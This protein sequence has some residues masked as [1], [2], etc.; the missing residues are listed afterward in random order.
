MR[1]TVMV[2]GSSRSQ[3][4]GSQT[5]SAGRWDGRE[6]LCDVWSGAH[7]PWAVNWRV[8][9]GGVS[10]F[11]S[12]RGFFLGDEVSVRVFDQHAAICPVFT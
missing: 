5:A 10:L 9:I 1:A 6:S 8:E 12:I 4:S 11:S 7:F 3:T 2:G